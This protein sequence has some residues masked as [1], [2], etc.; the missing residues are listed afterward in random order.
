MSHED[1]FAE[2]VGVARGFDLDRLAGEIVPRPPGRYA[3]ASFEP[4]PPTEAELVERY[5]PGALCD[6]MGV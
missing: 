5:G 6:G 1:I 3:Y 2:F 4:P